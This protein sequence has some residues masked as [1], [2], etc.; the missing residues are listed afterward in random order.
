MGRGSRHYAQ[1]NQAHWRRV[2]WAVLR[3]DG[4][5]CQK[6]G[7]A[8]R[9]EVHHVQALEAGGDPYDL[10]NLAAICRSCHIGLHR[11]DNIDRQAALYPQAAAWR[12]AV[13]DLMME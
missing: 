1:L 12:R 2:R 6:C 8:G 9:L 11:Q 13:D 5:R 4:F 7:K 3:R 10:G